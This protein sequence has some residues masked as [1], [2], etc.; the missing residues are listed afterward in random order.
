[1]AQATHPIGHQYFL[2]SRL[3][4]FSINNT[5]LHT[6]ETNF[7]EIKH[8]D[9]NKSKYF[10]VLEFYSGQLPNPPVFK[11]DFKWLKVIFERI[12]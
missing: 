8:D 10:K 4:D 7:S 3:A 12:D 9:S 2:E 11:K 6:V 1:M 5:I